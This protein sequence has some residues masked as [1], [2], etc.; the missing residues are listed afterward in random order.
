MAALAAAGACRQK[1]AE[2]RG[3][4]QEPAAQTAV[5]K[6]PELAS[7]VHMGDPQS[8]R[9]L[10]SG[11]YGIENNAWRWTAKK[12]TATLH[13][14]AGAREGG[15]VLNLN[16]T[17]PQVTIDKLRSVTLAA[18]VNGV[19]L[20]SATF[21]TPGSYT[22][23]RDVPPSAFKSDVS[24]A[25]FTLDKALPPGQPDVRELGVVALAVGLEAK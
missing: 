11:F 20:P 9:Q 23:K 1:S 17:V 24:R 19:P 16:F 21:S 4:V 8:A 6:A 2:T 22:Y 25:E 7:T 5:Q 10:E 14:P 3:T 12:F 18:A 13:T 15:A